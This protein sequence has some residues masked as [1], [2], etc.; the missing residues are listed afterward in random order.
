MAG[1]FLRELFFRSLSRDLT[2]ASVLLP[3]VDLCE[4]FVALFAPGRSA[5]FAIY[6]FCLDLSRFSEFPNELL[7]FNCFLTPSISLSI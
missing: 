1:H 2:A 5:A 6:R 3:I 4:L 7:D